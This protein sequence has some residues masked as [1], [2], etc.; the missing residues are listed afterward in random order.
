MVSISIL[1]YPIV[2]A[3]LSTL[4]HL[5]HMQN[6]VESK[7]RETRDANNND[8][9]QVETHAINMISCVALYYNKGASGT[10]CMKKEKFRASIPE[11]VT[12]LKRLKDLISYTLIFFS[13]SLICT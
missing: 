13:M 12:S 1:Y 7:C 11:E 2:V 3:T 9:A 5:R 4:V 8:M 10:N 6:N